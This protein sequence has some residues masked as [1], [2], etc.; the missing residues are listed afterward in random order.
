[1]LNAKCTMQ[2]AK[3]ERLHVSPLLHFDFCILNYVVALLVVA[4][5]VGAAQIGGKLIVGGNPTPG[6]EQPAPPNVA[7]RITLTGC[8][9]AAPKNTATNDAPDGNMPSDARFM[10]ADAERIDRVPADTGGSPATATASGRS[11]RLLGIESQFSPFVNTKVEISG[12]IKPVP[13]SGSDANG[14]PTLVVE[15]VQKL[16]STCK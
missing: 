4:T 2:N 15:F 7:D 13:P 16:A 11:Y 12:E 3:A 14:P 8:L 9:Q 6:T 10:L 5:S 1:M